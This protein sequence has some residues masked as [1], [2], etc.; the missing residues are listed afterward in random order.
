MTTL[1]LVPGSTAACRATGLLEVAENRLGNSLGVAGRDSESGAAAGRRCLLSGAVP[2]VAAAAL[3]KLARCRRHAHGLLGRATP[4]PWPLE[5]SDES[6][7]SRSSLP[8]AGF[9]SFPRRV[10]FCKVAVALQNLAW[11]RPPDVGHVMSR[12]K[13][14]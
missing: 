7:V 14:F 1:V 8:S 5:D 10:R 9:L 12:D 2:R 13:V 6:K 3:F 4:Q 11:A